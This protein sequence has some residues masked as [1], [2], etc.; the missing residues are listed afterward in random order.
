MVFIRAPRIEQ[1]GPE[2]EVLARQGS[3]PVL[4]RQG[5]VMA[6]TFH[7][8]LSQDRRVHEYFLKLIRGQQVS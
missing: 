8:E 5:K 3:D 6:A 4:I 7:P 1:L 2:V